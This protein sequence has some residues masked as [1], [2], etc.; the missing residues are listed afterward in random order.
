MKARIPP[1]LVVLLVAA[2][3][4]ALAR[5]GWPGAFDFPGRTWVAALFLVPG[6]L[7]PA[8]GVH[9]F[10]SADTTVDPLHP[11]KASA[12][13]VRGIYSRTRNP[14]YLGFAFLLLGWAV[15]LGSAWS[16]LGLPLYVL[17]MNR[18]QIGPEEEALELRFGEAFREY[19]SRVRRWI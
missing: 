17:W 8:L 12:L 13:V 2:A 1:V 19:M 3:M 4:R 7:L 18:F 9:R 11:E 15:G 5:A 10:R 6:L 14:M 16:L